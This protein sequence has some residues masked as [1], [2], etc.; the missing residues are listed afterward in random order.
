M[1]VISLVGKVDKRILAFPLIRALSIEGKTVVYTDDS[2]FKNLF[3]G[4]SNIGIVEDI[5]I[6]YES[7]IKMADETK[8]ISELAKHIVFVYTDFIKEDSDI[9]FNCSNYDRSFHPDKTELEEEK[10]ENQFDLVFSSVPLRKVPSVLVMKPIYYRY[11]LE[12]EEKKEFLILK[13]KE[14]N[15]FLANKVSSK[16][17]MPKEQF[18]KLLSRKRNPILI[19]QKRR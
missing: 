15:T 11:L 13:D 4:N 6:I 2:N 17:D 16:V 8:Y 7:N 19:N 5:T 10:P 14:I 9:I 1:A 18:L 3:T 12:T